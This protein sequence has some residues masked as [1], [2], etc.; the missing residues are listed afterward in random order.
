LTFIMTHLNPRE[1]GGEINLKAKRRWEILR[2]TDDYRRDWD[3]AFAKMVQRLKQY[4]VVSCDDFEGEQDPEKIRALM[5][6]AMKDDNWQAF[7]EKKWTT[8]KLK[9]EFLYP[10]YNPEGKELADKYGLFLPY[11]YDAPLWD[12]FKDRMKSVFKDMLAVRIITQHPTSYKL[13]PDRKTM[14]ADHTPHLRERRYLTFEIDLY[15][16]QGMILKLIKS[17][18]D[19]YQDLLERPKA[20][21][22]DQALEFYLDS[23]KGKFS[24]YEL[25]D[26]NKREGKSPWEIAQTLC[27]SLTNAKSYQPAS[28]NYDPTVR[29]LWKRIDDGIKKADSEINSPL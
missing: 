6:E 14:L 22:R 1:P 25:W 29:S 8:A 13:S 24:I 2:R 4:C 5:D 19:F 21:K 7:V 26:M 3:A 20:K 27:P 17:Q 16:K 12:P 10:H 9:E 11:H 15:E 18:L 23:E 28:K